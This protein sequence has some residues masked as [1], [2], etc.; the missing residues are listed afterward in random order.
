MKP[1]ELTDNA[2]CPLVEHLVFERRSND[3]ASHYMNEPHFELCTAVAE[4]T[5][6]IS[7]AG[8]GRDRTARGRVRARAVN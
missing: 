5:S 3:S 4:Q 2:E 7:A 1:V 8:T 6:A